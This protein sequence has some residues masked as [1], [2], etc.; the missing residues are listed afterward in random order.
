MASY[1]SV[2]GSKFVVF[3]L[4]FIAGCA[5]LPS[6]EEILNDPNA[7]AKPRLVSNKGILS[8][9][10]SQAILDGL[11]RRVG[12]KDI[13]E[14]HLAATEWVAGSPL[15][16]GNAVLLLEDGPATY[17]AM[18]EA[19]KKAKDHINIETYIIEDDEIGREFANLLIEKQ[20][21]GVQV[22]LIYDS[23]GSISTPK[24]FFQ[25]LE[26]AGI[27]TLEF[28]PVNPLASKK[29]WS[30]NRRDHRKIIVID[31]ATAFTGGLNIS[32]VYSSAGFSR[33]V[34]R[35]EARKDAAWR[36]T[37]VQIDGPVVAEFQKMFMETWEKQKGEPL[38]A[39]NY[40]PFIKEKGNLI[41]RAVGSS[42]DLPVRQAYVLLLTAIMS[43]EDYINL[44]MAY[45]VPDPNMTNALKD[46]ARRGV[47]VKIVLPSFTD[48]WAVFHAGRSNY[49][50]LMEAGVRIYEHQGALLHAKTAVIDNVWSTVGSTNLDWRSFLYNDEVNAVVL[51][52]D[53]ASKLDATFAR[54]LQ[55]SREITSEE[56]ARRPISVR[57]KEWAARLWERWL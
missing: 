3:G 1:L 19:I 4:L 21:R 49:T 47:K 11:Q 54:D 36:D 23:V 27:K 34:R 6:P 15:V 55:E 5:S 22:N 42:A 30:L 32:A 17:K 12:K 8:E 57:F 38:A 39:R 16:L 18:Y 46:A 56:W 24:S 41:V 51:G 43:A 7:T 25:R 2:L 53:F 28:N 14:R 35:F 37:H 29:E 13:I 50:E 10:Q 9:K 26:A 45:F 52:R 44:T 33:P 31:G 20:A 40:F 48:F